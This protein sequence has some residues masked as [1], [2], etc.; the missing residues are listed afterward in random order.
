MKDSLK[1]Y[2]GNVSACIFLLC[3]LV[4]L[5]LYLPAT[6]GIKLGL[7]SVEIGHLVKHAIVLSLSM[8]SLI[9][10]VA[11]P[12]A[13]LTVSPL[14]RKF[15]WSL[16]I[17]LSIF[18]IFHWQHYHIDMSELVWHTLFDTNLIESREYLAVYFNA[19][20]LSVLILFLS[21]FIIFNEL[22]KRIRMEV[23]FLFLFAFLCISGFSLFLKST[24][25]RYWRNNAVVQLVSSIHSYHTE[26]DWLA[27]QRTMCDTNSVKIPVPLQHAGVTVVVVGESSSRSHFSLYGYSRPTTPLL[28]ARRGELWVVDQV[29]TEQVHTNESL[30]KVFY[31][32]DSCSLVQSLKKA[33]YQTAW[34]SN[35]APLGQNERITRSLAQQTDKHFFV[36]EIQGA[37]WDERI[38]PKLKQY[39]ES[40]NRGSVVFLHLMGTHQDYHERYPPKFNFFEGTQSAFGQIAGHRIDHYDNAIRYNDWLLDSLINMLQSQKFPTSLIYFSDHGD[41]VYDY[42]DF[43][44]HHQGLISSYM[45]EVPFIGWSSKQ[46]SS[47][48]LCFRDGMNLGSFASRFLHWKRNTLPSVKDSI[49]TSPYDITHNGSK[50][51]DSLSEIWAHRCNSVER[52]RTLSTAFTGFEIDLYWNGEVWEVNHPP[53]ID[54]SLPL[55]QFFE[56]VGKTKKRFW[57]DLKNLDKDNLPQLQ[58]DI[59]QLSN[60]GLLQGPV[61]LETSELKLI[62]ALKLTG[63]QVSF[64][65]PSRT[66]ANEEFHSLYQS[67][68]KDP[69]IKEVDYLSQDLWYLNEMER[70]FPEFQFLTWYGTHEWKEGES[71]KKL[72][73]ILKEHPQIRVCLINYPSP[74][75]R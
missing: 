58:S 74:N 61:I 12:I 41:E 50:K 21:G 10:L 24:D 5:P 9:F 7:S 54:E 57:M 4:L 72:Q 51:Q 68:A 44:G 70:Y 33:G 17:L 8:S 36:Q 27:M 13:F 20:D 71:R 35:Q 53:T 16:L 31:N 34:I 49:A 38:L 60:L 48:T 14:I 39:L 69:R 42:R 32:T 19:K 67:L 22:V 11:F 46:D 2:L 66:G 63:H 56:Q 30:K 64:Y 47:F 26:N 28:V 62:S 23:K 6:N 29:Y 55:T 43:V 37:G 25:L 45:T 59:E 75:W 40:T 52:I 73:R 15:L 18:Q 1:A 3:Y 65:L